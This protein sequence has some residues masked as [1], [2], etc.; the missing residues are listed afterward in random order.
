M[1]TPLASL[2]RLY[3]CALQSMRTSEEEP[4]A[5][6]EGADT[7]DSRWQTCPK[8]AWWILGTSWV[9]VGVTVYELVASFQECRSFSLWPWRTSSA[10]DK[11]GAARKIHDTPW[12]RVGWNTHDHCMFCSCAPEVYRPP[13]CRFFLHISSR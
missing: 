2:A 7:D 1:R 10:A 4:H 9:K 6:G 12:L 3:W 13:I 5:S 8:S 11:S